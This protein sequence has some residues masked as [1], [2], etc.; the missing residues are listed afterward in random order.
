MVIVMMGSAHSLAHG[1]GPVN[2]STEMSGHG[3]NGKISRTEN[4]LEARASELWS[5][6]HTKIMSPS[7]W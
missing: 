1:E 4:D 6:C 3:G 7:L 2:A 5:L